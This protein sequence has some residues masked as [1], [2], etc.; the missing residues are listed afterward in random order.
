MIK[1][2]EKTK[3]VVKVRRVR[4]TVELGNSLGKVVQFKKVPPGCSTDT[5]LVTG[6]WRHSGR[7][8]S[9]D[10]LS[11]PK[12]LSQRYVHAGSQEQAYIVDDKEYAPY[13]K[14]NLHRAF[15]YM[16][17]P[18][19]SLGT[20]PEVF[21]LDK[22]GVVIPAFAFLPDK[23]RAEG[24]PFWDGFQAEL[25]TNVSHSPNN[26]CL[27]YLT[28]DVH[29]GLVKL[30]DM[31]KE[32]NEDASLSWES[33][34]EVPR[35]MM[36][37]AKPEHVELGCAP[38][39]NAYPYI[40]PMRVENPAKLL[41]RFAGCHVHLGFGTDQDGTGPKITSREMARRVKFIDAIFGPLSTYLFRGMED[42]RR[43][44]YYGRAGEF[45]M[46]PWGLEYRV[47]SSAMMSHPVL[48]HLCFDMIRIASKIYETPFRD[49]WEYDEDDVVEA[50]NEY[51]VKLAKK[52]L[53]K[54]EGV[55][56]QLINRVYYESRKVTETVMSLIDLG[57]L[58]WFGDD[59]YDMTKNWRLKGNW[60]SHSGSRNCCVAKA[61]RKVVR[62]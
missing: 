56:K 60:E 20:D 41:V 23:R 57:A 40:K 25:T 32:Y 1:V 54:N 46:P 10:F 3:G 59:I 19:Y 34:V 58:E 11:G 39:L 48:F 5:G 12:L 43:R 14:A 27:A 49:L 21:V 61:G 35:E 51:D 31:A 38:S 18:Y 37:S 24:K 42:P 52:I 6:C 9:I 53:T 55:L 2:A 7:E 30:Y 13:L 47:P 28:D 22:D 29:W 17:L 36:L 4:K 50:I 45:R 33:V 26:T 62:K 44:L 15:R 8:V 16:A